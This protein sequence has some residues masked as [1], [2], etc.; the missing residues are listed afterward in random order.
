MQG[1]TTCKVLAA[2]LRNPR[3]VRECAIAGAHVA[4]MPF[5]VMRGMAEH[6]QTLGGMKAFTADIVAEY[7]ALFD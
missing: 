4:T 3:Q 5:D 6:P 7:A 2:S 1:I